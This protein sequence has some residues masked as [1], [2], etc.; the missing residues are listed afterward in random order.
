ML[1]WP[2]SHTRFLAPWH[3]LPASPM[4]PSLFGSR[5]LAIMSW[6]ALLFSPLVVYAFWPRRPLGT[7]APVRS[8]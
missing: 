7:R 2:F 5:G 3:P 4:G 1:L 6:E 8:S